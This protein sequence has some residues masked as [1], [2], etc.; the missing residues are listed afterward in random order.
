MK[1]QIICMRCSSR[2]RSA[3]I[4]SGELCHRIYGE[5]LADE[6]C[7]LCHRT[8]P[9]GSHCC[10]ETIVAKEIDY[11]LLEDKFIHIDRDGGYDG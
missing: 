8:I 10:A 1:R 5:V 7:E 4:A 2:Q 11:E 6:S 3:D 9:K